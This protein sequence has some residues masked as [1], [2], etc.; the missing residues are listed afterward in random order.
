[1]AYRLASTGYPVEFERG[2]ARFRKGIVIFFLFIMIPWLFVSLVPQSLNRP[3]DETGDEPIQIPKYEAV[4]VSYP[5]AIRYVFIPPLALET[6]IQ[7]HYPGSL[8]DPDMLTQI[9]AAAQQ[10]DVSVPLLLGILGAEQSFLQPAAVGYY[11]AV[12]FVANPFDY[13][14]WPGSPYAFSIG[15]EKS[16]EGAAELVART[17][18]AMPPGAWSPETYRQFFGTLENF[19]VRGVS[20]MTSAWGS[21]AN[22]VSSLFQA[23][24]IDGVEAIEAEAEAN[25]GEVAR[26]WRQ[27][28]A[29]AAQV[30]ADS[31]QAAD[32]AEVALEAGAGEVETGIESGAGAVVGA[33]GV[34]TGAVAT[35]AKVIDLFTR[36]VLVDEGVDSAT[37]D[38]VGG[39]L[40]GV[41]EV[42]GDA[43][44]GALAA[45]A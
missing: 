25:A 18:E 31:A 4:P 29:D 39:L 40:D 30:W 32:Q 20:E 38:T 17:V 19:Y 15:A 33:V 6:W 8:V 45:A 12:N 37:A 43:A 1:M 26:I 16:A 36:K 10:A 44:V 5:Q 35:K 9:E 22:N 14:V 41:V 27:V 11:H 13:G 34:A 21:W 23:T 24:T 42:G 7:A 3:D 28:S 2:L